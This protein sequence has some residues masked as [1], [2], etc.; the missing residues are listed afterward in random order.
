MLRDLAKSLGVSDSI[1]FVG[2]LPNDKLPE[3]LAS[4]DIYVSTSLSD[5]GI[6]AST[7]EAMACELPVII[8]DFG[9][10]G[11][12]VKNDVNGFL[13]P[14]KNPELLADYII[15]LLKNPEIC[16]EFGRKN[17]VIIEEFKNLDKEM[18][19]IENIYIDLVQRC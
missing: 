17:R 10:N 2:F 1:L 18:G 19:K 8:T 9:D 12:W 15:Y 7:S 3:Y 6:A 14:L 11:K 5:A 4:A 16:R 13:I